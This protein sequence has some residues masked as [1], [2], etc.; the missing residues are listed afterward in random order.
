MF[1][2]YCFKKRADDFGY[3]VL[4]MPKDSYGP[5]AQQSSR[6]IN[7]PHARSRSR[8]QQYPKVCLEDLITLQALRERN[9]RKLSNSPVRNVEFRLPAMNKQRQFPLRQSGGSAASERDLYRKQQQQQQQQ[10][11]QLQ[12]QQ[13]Q[14]Q[15]TESPSPSDLP[16][17]ASDSVRDLQDS[18]ADFFNIIYENV[19]DAVN[20]AVELTVE[21][22][23]Q[24]I[25]SNVNQLTSEMSVQKNMLKQINSDLMNMTSLEISEL[26]ET[27]LNQFKFIAQML[28]DSQTF[29]YR[30]LNQQRLQRQQNKNDLDQPK[31]SASS[32][33]IV[34]PSGGCS[35]CQNANIRTT[36]QQPTQR[37][38]HHLWQQ[39]DANILERLQP[40]PCKDCGNQRGSKKAD[41]TILRRTVKGISTVSMPDLHQASSLSSSNPNNSNNKTKTQ[42]PQ[43]SPMP[44]NWAQFGSRRVV[45][46][47]TPPTNSSFKKCRCHCYSPGPS[48]NINYLLSNNSSLGRKLRT[49]S[50]TLPSMEDVRAHT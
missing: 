50:K 44:S 27:N 42:R 26:N 2:N 4:Y 1:P 9:E 24:D 16:S 10:Q 3:E 40:K 23:F 12:Q 15:P 21:K 20:G 8:S 47:T 7:Q 41:R 11:H 46:Q 35:R 18:C 5:N 38:Q 30:A 14:H 22:H 49:L 34:R 29:H 39:Q 48:Q 33:R 17:S 37:P 19:L 13:Q 43:K 36:P 45:N 31:R 32:E 25:I 6:S 28:I